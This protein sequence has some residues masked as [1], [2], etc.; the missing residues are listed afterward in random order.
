[1]N[2]DNE[3]TRLE[4]EFFH[5]IQS[6]GRQ[7][8]PKQQQLIDELTAMCP[9]CCFMIAE[10]EKTIHIDEFGRP[11]VVDLEERRQT[12][13]EWLG[14]EILHQLERQADP[15]TMQ[16]QRMRIAELLGH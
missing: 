10:D 13:D 2:D 14:A 15:E 5:L 6:G 9:G 8:T 16:R 1:M 3:I 7:L 4:T 11:F 12:P